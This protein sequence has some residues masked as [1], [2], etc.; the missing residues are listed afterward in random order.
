M[1]TANIFPAMMGAFGLVFIL[2]I[3]ILLAIWI[4]LPFSIFGIKDLIREA[5][6]E[7]KKTNELLKKLLDKKSGVRRRDKTFCL[8]NS[9][10]FI[11]KIL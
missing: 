11:P 5:I 8:L 2:L 1:N 6:E 9:V 4:A 7:Q 3:F 10:F